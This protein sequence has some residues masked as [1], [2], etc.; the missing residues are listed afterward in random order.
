MIKKVYILV[1]L[2]AY[3]SCKNKETQINSKASNSTI[4]S[5]KSVPL[6]KNLKLESDKG[7]IEHFLNIND[8]NSLYEISKKVT[9]NILKTDFNGDGKLDVVSIVKEM[10]TE[11]LGLIFFHS[12]N[13]YY[14]IGAGKEF[15]QDGWDDMNWLGVFE[16]DHSKK[17]VITVF[18]EETYDIIDEKEVLIPNVGVRIGEKEGSGGLLY[19]NG[20]EYNYLHQGD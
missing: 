20:K 1:I 13:E 11:Q 7:L 19:F 15:T 12:K 14:V 4:D 17:Q 5:L 6:N 2:L 16:L 18:D 8:L 3:L 10:S 9:P